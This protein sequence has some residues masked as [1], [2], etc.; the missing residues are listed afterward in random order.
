MKIAENNKQAIDT[1]FDKDGTTFDILI[2][3]RN[4]RSIRF[5]YNNRA[6]TL[7]KHGVI[8]AET[9]LDNGKTW[10]TF[11]DFTTQ[12]ALKGLEDQLTIG[13]DHNGRYYK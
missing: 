6:F 9:Q 2:I 4:K 7:N 13:S 8:C 3:K 12:D 1:L 5:S 10:F 11:C